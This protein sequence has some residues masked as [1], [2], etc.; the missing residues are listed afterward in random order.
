[1]AL[2]FLH[3]DGD[4]PEFVDFLYEKGYALFHRC[5]TRRGLVLNRQE[6]V[7]AMQDDL[8]T[9][10]GTYTIGSPSRRQILDLDFCGPQAHP[11]KLGRQGRLAGRIS[12]PGEKDAE[13]ELLMRLLRNYFRRTYTFQRYNGAARMSCHFGP[14]YQKMEADFF[15]DPRMESL[16]TGFL[17]MLCHPGQEDGDMAARLLD[18]PEVRNAQISV[19]PYWAD[20]GLVELYAPFLYDTT[21]FD[22]RAYADM[23]ARLAGPGSDVRIYRENLYIQISNRISAEALRCDTRTKGVELL[24]ARPWIPFG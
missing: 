18:R 23:A 13:S 4:I 19:R 2:E 6:A 12:V 1:M 21:E 10:W 7:Y 5:G 8:H 24:M 22:C 14:H 20:H 15:A 11:S 9:S 3:A 17:R 16:C